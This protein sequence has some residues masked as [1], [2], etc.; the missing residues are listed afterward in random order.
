[1]RIVEREQAMFN[2]TVDEAHTFFVGDGQWLIFNNQCNYK[3][4]YCPTML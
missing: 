2:L 3:R 1:M 4:G